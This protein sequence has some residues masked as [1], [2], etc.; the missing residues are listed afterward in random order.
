VFA[1]LQNLKLIIVDER[2]ET[3]YKQ[4]GDSTAITLEIRR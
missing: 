1:P 3:T 2:H 4:E